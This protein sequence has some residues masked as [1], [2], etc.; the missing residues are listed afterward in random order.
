M[1]LVPVEC[2]TQCGDELEE[3]ET[4]GFT[5]YQLTKGKRY[6]NWNNEQPV[7]IDL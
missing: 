6:E 1:K 2:A 4:F 7:K 3:T 5:V